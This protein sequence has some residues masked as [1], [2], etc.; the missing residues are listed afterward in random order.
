MST[1]SATQLRELYRYLYLTRAL[2]ER[3]ENLFKQGQIVGGLYRSL[4]QEATAVGSAYALGEEDWVAPSI[5]DLGA[6][7]VRGVEPR[8]MLRQYM[9][10]DNP[11]TGGRDNTTHFTVP[12]LGILGP[13]SPLGTQ[14]SVLNGVALAFRVRSEDRVCL[15]YQGDG[16]SRTGA[17]HEGMNFAAVQDLPMVAVL[18]HNRWAFSTPSDAEAAVEDWTDVAAAYDVPVEQVDGN[19]VLE[20]YDATRRAVGRARDGGG[21]QLVVAETYRMLGHAQHDDQEYVPGEELEAWRERDPLDR[22]EAYLDETGVA[23]GE[24]RR[25]IRDD[26]EAGLDEAVQEALDTPRPEPSDAGSRVWADEDGPRVPWTR[27]SPVGYD[28]APADVPPAARETGGEE[29]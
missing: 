23:D 7:L 8:L 4:G 22:Y 12:E 11:M 15:A 5:R 3:F 14:I 6:I 26:V 25:E 9:A 18:E 17:H 10:R 24:R 13:I 28:D 19:H 20:V 1:L 2:E 27:R 21:M 16:A 29:T